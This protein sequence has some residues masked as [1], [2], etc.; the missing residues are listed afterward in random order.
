[1]SLQYLIYVHELIENG[2]IA[3]LH[4][5]FKMLGNPRRVGV[6]RTAKKNKNMASRVKITNAT[7]TLSVEATCSQLHT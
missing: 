1:M 4:I 7:I 5:A 3:Y 6:T 2:I